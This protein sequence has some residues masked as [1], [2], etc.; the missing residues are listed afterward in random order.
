MPSGPERTSSGGCKERSKAVR[1]RGSP[2]TQHGGVVR[3]SEKSPRSAVSQRGEG[4][5]MIDGTVGI[6]GPAGGAAVTGG[7]LT[8]DGAAF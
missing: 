8:N 6:E 7:I 3:S 4:K 1:E 5:W 2:A